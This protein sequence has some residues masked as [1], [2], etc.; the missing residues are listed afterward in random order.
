MVS[1]EA[2]RDAIAG[3]IRS[4]VGGPGGRA[5]IEEVFSA[6]GPRWFD[7]ARPIWEVHADSSMFIGGIRAVLLQ[8][9]HP[10][11]M[12]GVAQHSDFRS[13][14][15]GRLQRTADFLTRTTYGTVEQAEAACAQVRAVHR[16][17]VGVAAD[18]RRYAANDPHLLAWVHIAE[19]DSFLTAHRRFGKRPLDR[20]ERDQYVADMAVVGRALGVVEPP[21]SVAAL[22]AQLAGFRPEL[23][24]TPEAREAA[25]FLVAPPLAPRGPRPVQRAGR[26][27]R[28]PLAAVGPPRPAAPARSGGRCRGRAA[29]RRRAH[30]ADPL[31]AG[32]ERSGVRGGLRLTTASTEREHPPVRPEPPRPRP[33]PRPR[34]ASPDPRCRRRRGRPGRPRTRAALALQRRLRRAVRERRRSVRWRRWRCSERRAAPSRWSWPSSG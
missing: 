32:T 13:D 4:R 8:S 25:R 15:W 14:P 28:R 1:M 30:A 23:E 18:G 34:P 33:R 12:A 11:A 9:L 22:R 6:D 7:R 21:R 17:V 5:R 26:G 16:R 27:R 29:R 19:V 20:T 10:L 2:L 24:A 31:G 3:A